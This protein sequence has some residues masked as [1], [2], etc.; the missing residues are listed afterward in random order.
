MV[1]RT[2]NKIQKT[3]VNPKGSL[4]DKKLRL[5]EQE[6]F[7]K[8]GGGLDLATLAKSKSELYKPTPVIIPTIM[9]AGMK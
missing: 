4:T 8:E 5:R 2:G 6:K 7:E 1:I 3:K 9:F